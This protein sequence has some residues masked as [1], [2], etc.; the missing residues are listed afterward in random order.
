MGASL[1]PSIKYKGGSVNSLQ[2][3][4]HT[5]HQPLLSC[6]GPSSGSPWLFPT[7]C[8]STWLLP[9]SVSEPTPTHTNNHHPVLFSPVCLVTVGCYSTPWLLS[10][11][12]GPLPPEE[13]VP[14]GQRKGLSALPLGPS[15]KA[16]TQPG[17]CFKG[18]I[19]GVMKHPLQVLLHP[20]SILPSLILWCSVY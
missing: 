6:K 7:L 10:S 11:M 8:L 14:W 19:G 20:S 4:D 18:V 15:S 9:L 5:A 12:C 2:F 1:F 3:L 16:T 17:R 13:E